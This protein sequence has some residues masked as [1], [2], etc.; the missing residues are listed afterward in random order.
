MNP[1][2][3]LSEAPKAVK[4]HPKI[5]TA[6]EFLEM[7]A[8]NPSVFE[9][10]D[11]PLE[12]TEY[13]SC[14]LSE[15]THLSPQLTFSGKDKAGWAADFMMATNLKNATGTFHG[16]VRFQ[17]SGIEK[18]E[19]LIVTKSD[20]DKCAAIFSYCANLKIATGTF[21]GCV[22]FS[23][24]GIHSIQNLHVQNP[25]ADKYYAYFSDCPNL[26]TLKGWD[27]SKKIWIEPEK[28]AAEKER[29]A[30][31]NSTKN[32]SWKNFPS[33]ENSCPSPKSRR[34]LPC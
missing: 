25:N 17:Q 13:V 7:I 1:A 11:S 19:K 12:I 5:I 10:W 33:Y 18:I 8:K 3:I 20:N 21:H 2:H 31:K 29:R 14:L 34:K 6:Q 24:S 23:E 15:I 26:K 32:H 27:L 16:H 22:D 9:H 4:S 30:S 28:L